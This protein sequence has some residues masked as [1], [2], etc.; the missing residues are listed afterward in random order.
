MKVCLAGLCLF[1]MDGFVGPGLRAFDAEN[2]SC[3]NIIEEE[4]MMVRE[5][6]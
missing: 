4:V 2:G 6:I 1:F 3:R 5:N